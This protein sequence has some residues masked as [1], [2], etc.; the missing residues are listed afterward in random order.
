[1]IDEAQT[2]KLAPN[3]F[4]PQH[5]TSDLDRYTENQRKVLHKMLHYS[6]YDYWSLYL[7]IYGF[8]YVELGEMDKFQEV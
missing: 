8:T 7:S 3:T 1:M 2:R 4:K 5:S 6:D